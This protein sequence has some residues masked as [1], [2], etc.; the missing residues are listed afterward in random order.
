MNEQKWIFGFIL[1]FV[2]I[3]TLASGVTPLPVSFGA[4][5]YDMHYASDPTSHASIQPGHWKT[6][7]QAFNNRARSAN[8]ITR[9]YPYSSDIEIT[10]PLQKQG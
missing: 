9:L 1:G 5:M 8:L 7:L 4:L 6:Q 3:Y 2:Q 10:Y